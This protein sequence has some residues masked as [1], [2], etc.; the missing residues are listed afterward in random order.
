MI[1]INIPICHRL[2]NRTFKIGKWYFP[3]C[4]RCTGIYLG[5]FFSYLLINIINI[6]YTFYLMCIAATV[7]FPTFF[8]A[9]TQFLGYRE[10]NNKLRF[11]TGLIAGFGLIIL[12]KGL[13][14]FL[15]IH[16]SLIN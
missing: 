4:S 12:A 14:L 9:T 7:S 10:S 3:V 8:D 16:W 5:I 15:G 11:S 6:D 1:M 2:P 13:K